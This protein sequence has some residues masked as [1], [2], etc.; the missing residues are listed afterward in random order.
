V[1]ICFHKE[2]LQVR[3]LG[4]LRSE[5][6]LGQPQLGPKDWASFKIKMAEIIG[7][8]KHIKGD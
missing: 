2:W 7:P 5:I 1:E 4:Y 6:E 3:V 8:Y